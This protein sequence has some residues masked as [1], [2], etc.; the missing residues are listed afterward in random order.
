MNVAGRLAID[1]TGAD[2]GTVTGISAQAYPEST[3]KAGSVSV[4]A[5][6]ASIVN[7]GIISSATFGPGDGGSVVM[8]VANG[9]LI[10]GT[11]ANPVSLTGIASEA[12]DPG[13]A[14]NVGNVSVRAGTLSLVNG[15]VISSTTFGRGN[16]GNVAVDVAGALSIDGSLAAS[17]TGIASQADRTSTGNAGAIAVKAGSLS[18]ADNGAISSTT[19][20]SFQAAQ[21]RWLF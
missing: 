8:D 13:S 12:V 19:R 21:I 5:R 7:N 14:A 2:P 17:F 6:D 10:D 4:S 11:G 1:G 3:G 16:G 20:L 15:G 18:I 9:L